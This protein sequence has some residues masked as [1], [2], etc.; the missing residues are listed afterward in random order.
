MDVY[1]CV[2]DL[3]SIESDP[4]IFHLVCYRRIDNALLFALLIFW[5]LGF[6]II[7]AWGPYQDEDLVS[8]L[9][10]VKKHL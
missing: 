5:L 3:P 8:L 2:L 1:A 4:P 7:P 10:S 9:W 6:R